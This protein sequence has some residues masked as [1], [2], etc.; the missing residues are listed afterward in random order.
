MH[1]W[2][3]IQQSIQKEQALTM[4]YVLESKGSS[5]GRQGFRMAV[6]ADG[7]MQGSIGGGIMEHKLVELAKS[8]LQK[9]TQDIQIKKQIHS[10][11]VAANQ[12]GMICSG[13]QTILLMP[14]S[15]NEGLTIDQIIS[16]LDNGQQGQLQLSPTGMSF[17]QSQIERANDFLY[18]DELNWTYKEQIGFSKFAYIIGGGHVGKA[19]TK[20]LVDLHFHCTVMDNRDKLHT[21]ENNAHAHQK[22]IVDY[23][24][25][26]QVIPEGD[27]VFI[28]IMT[29]G[30]RTDKEVLQQLIDHRVAYKGM[31][32]SAEKVSHLK[33]DIKANGITS[34]QLQSIH[35]PIG[36]TIKSRTPEEI[37]ISIA[38]QV[39]QLQNKDLP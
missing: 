9:E 31:M 24:T 28:F 29:F 33:N 10:K 19:L 11:S 38:A 1:F 5:P 36:L 32:G 21:I 27:N 30:Y 22:K 18:T 6:T 7:Q 25:I 16:C 39:I 23:S 13:E 37:A 3:F 17:D 20:V 8:N 26:Q 4:L 15:G 35:S 14:L 12:S 34:K 2:K